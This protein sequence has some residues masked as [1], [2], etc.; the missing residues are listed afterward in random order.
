[1]LTTCPSGSLGAIA[2]PL[3]A[4]QA[5]TAGCFAKAGQ[6]PCVSRTRRRGAGFEA[7]AAE[8]AAR[9]GL[10]PGRMRLALAA[11]EAGWP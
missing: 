6:K 4:D 9:T 8:L 1:M 2:R 3:P 7:A 5:G 11:A 10:G